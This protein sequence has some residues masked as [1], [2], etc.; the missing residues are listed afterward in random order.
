MKCSQG[1]KGSVYGNRESAFGEGVLSLF[2]VPVIHLEETT[3]GRFRRSNII[4]YKNS[5]R[6]QFYRKNNCRLRR[7][8][9]L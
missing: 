3:D 2:F 7:V 8:W 9:Q 6:Q 5:F 1:N 4:F